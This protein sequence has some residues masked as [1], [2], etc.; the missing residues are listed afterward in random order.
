MADVP[1]PDDALLDARST[2][3]RIRT[4]FEVSKQHAFERVEVQ[5][6]D[7][8]NKRALGLGGLFG[9]HQLEGVWP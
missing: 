4:I 5:L 7:F 1:F 6:E 2:E 8:R 9:D 3:E